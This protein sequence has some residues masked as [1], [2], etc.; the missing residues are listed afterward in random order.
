MKEIFKRRLIQ[1]EVKGGFLYIP[2]K[3]VEFMPDTKGKIECKMDGKINKLTYNYQ[4]RRIFGLTQWYKRNKVEAG[5]EVGLSMEN[6]TYRL[7]LAG[8]EEKELIDHRPDNIIDTSGLT[9]STK[10]DIVE[11]RI[12]DLIL[13]YGQGLLSV[14]KPVTDTEGI[15]L[16]VVKNGIY[17]PIFLQVKSRFKLH[18]TGSFIIDVRKKTFNPHHSFFVVGAYFDPKTIEIDENL[19][20]LPSEKVLNGNVVNKNNPRFRI[21]TRL[22]NSRGRW[23]KYIIKKTTLAEN[24]LEKFSEMSRYIK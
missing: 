24:L 17:Q 18:E 11:D 15:D 22:S 21:S 5:D 12:K 2:S 4:Y 9:S 3:G 1:V 8:F 20:F 7:E 16:I 13:L 10:G 19:I 6:N 14:Y 23:A